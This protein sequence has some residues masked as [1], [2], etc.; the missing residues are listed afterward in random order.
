MGRHYGIEDDGKYHALLIA[1]R[2]ISLDHLEAGGFTRN[3]I[4]AILATLEAVSPGASYVNMG[5]SVNWPEEPDAR[6]KE[7]ADAIV[8]VILAV[9]TE[10]SPVKVRRALLDLGALGALP[11]ALWRQ[12]E[13]RHQLPTSEP[14][15]YLAPAGWT[16][17]QLFEP[18]AA[19]TEHGEFPGAKA[20]AG[21]SGED[22]PPGV[23]LEVPK[24]PEEF[25]LAAH[26]A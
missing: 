5:T 8:G 11:D 6:I 13:E 14:G 9:A 7:G 3:K 17:A 25:W 26:Y 24:L 18:A 19:H 2:R 10:P 12:L 21:T 23:K 1:G 15:I 16:V 20:L 4:Q 22:F